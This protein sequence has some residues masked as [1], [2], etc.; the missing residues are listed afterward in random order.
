MKK[1]LLEYI[2]REC[3]KE[4]LET[5]PNGVYEDETVGAPAPPEGGQGTADTMAA[6]PTSQEQPTSGPTFTAD[7]KGVW[8]VDPKKIAK[9][10]QLKLV[11]K[12]PA[13]LERELY[14]IASRSGG[15][16]LKISSATLRE[17]PRTQANPAAAVFLYIGKNNPDDPDD[18]LYLLPAKSYQQAKQGSVAP[19]VSA[20]HP[21][22]APSTPPTDLGAIRQTTMQGG[23]TTAP[24]ISEGTNYNKMISHMV[25]EAIQKNRK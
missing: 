20:E 25:K 2:V 11:S 12:D 4:L 13:S 19:G 18:E 21:Y 16:R 5:F 23:K 1:Q 6:D 24:D 14:K 8:Y 17:V 3:V 10:Q 15:P 9:P 7:T 22:S